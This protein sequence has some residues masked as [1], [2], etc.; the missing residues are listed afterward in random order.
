MVR[1]QKERRVERLPPT[2]HYK[3]A[4]QPLHD[5]DD[6]IITIEEMEAIRLADV[7]MLDQ[8]AAAQ[9]M[10][11]SRPTF[12]RMLNAAHQKIAAALWQGKALRVEGGNFRIDHQCSQGMR[13]V[14]CHDCGHLWDVP[15]GTGQRCRD[16][17]CPQCGST[18][19]R[20]RHD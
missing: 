17:E 1:P 10:E 8:A 18:F 15:H 5:M 11:I 12:H 4:G 20:R 9:R 2:S 6:I 14:L 19:V 16:M 13:H 7:E 3:P